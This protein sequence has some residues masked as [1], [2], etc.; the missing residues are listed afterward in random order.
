MV[1][2]DHLFHISC[3]YKLKSVHIYDIMMI[4]TNILRL[5]P[6]F[7]VM[8]RLYNGY[9]CDQYLEDLKENLKKHFF[10]ASHCNP[11]FYLDF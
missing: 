1:S 8:P 6:H 3:I 10:T 11:D 5:I 2:R 4:T 9:Q 7:E